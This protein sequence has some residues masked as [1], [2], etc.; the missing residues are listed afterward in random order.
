M[1]AHGMG[2]W[3]SRA[4]FYTQL[5]SSSELE[6]SA[7]FTLGWAARGA[8]TSLLCTVQAVAAANAT[9]VKEGDPSLGCVNIR[10]GFHSGPV[11]ASVVGAKNP[12]YCLFGDT[13]NTASR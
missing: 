4:D 12:R 10:V 3:R 7:A 8:M 5:M 2:A 6:F 11:V 9:P 1:Q 13:V